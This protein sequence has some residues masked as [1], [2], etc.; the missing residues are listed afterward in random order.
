MSQDGNAEILPMKIPIL[1][2]VHNNND[3]M[4][5]RVSTEGEI[6]TAKERD[7]RNEKLTSLGAC[8]RSSNVAS[9]V[10]G[11]LMPPS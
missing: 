8:L 10:M 3:L 2:C 4:L 7:Q 1:S 9:M 5:D 6:A 11:T